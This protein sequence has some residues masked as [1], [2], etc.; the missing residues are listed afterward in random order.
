MRSSVLVALA[1][2]LAVSAPAAGQSWKTVNKAR[3]HGGQDVLD[4]R[5]KYAVGRFELAKGPE[6][7]LYRLDSRFDENLFKLR[8]NYLESGKRGSLSIELEGFDDIELKGLK[9]YEVEAGSLT[10]GL[11]SRTPLNLKM[12]LGAVEAHLDLGGLRV[13]E[14]VLQT[15]ASDTHIR[16]SEPNPEAADHCTFKA[17][18]A[19]L[20]VD[21]LGNS[22]CRSISVKGGVGTLIL[23]YSGQWKQDATSD[24]HVGLGTIEIRVPAEL[25]V[26]IDRS[27]F[28]MAF[29][30]PGFV[31]QDGGIWLSRNWDTA[32]RRLSLSVSGAVGGITVARL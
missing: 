5:I 2:L 18:A 16:F 30:A 9:D 1:A 3:Q 4:V 15:G 29:K 17:G 11:S 32:K 24:I 28:L 12:E 6:K 31:E 25:G 10:V 22:R 20:R 13:H 8:S 26:R 19:S 7:L 14:L 27:T 23:D 21:K